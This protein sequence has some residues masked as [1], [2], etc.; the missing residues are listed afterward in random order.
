MNN[1]PDGAYDV[2]FTTGADWD[3]GA[4]TRSCTFKRQEK[5]GAFSTQWKTG[6]AY[7]YSILSITL[8][9][10]PDGTVPI[11]DVPPSSFPK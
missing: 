11:A 1:I 7:T 6:G 8:H 2:F 9:P 3:G 4:F 10:V 5:S